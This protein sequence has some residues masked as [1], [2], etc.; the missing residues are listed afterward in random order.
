MKHPCSVPALSPGV[1][2]EY[3]VEWSSCPL[4]GFMLPLSEP[5]PH[6][7]VHEKVKCEQCGPF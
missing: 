2:D 6:M 4:T 1:T 7:A 3:V 5:A